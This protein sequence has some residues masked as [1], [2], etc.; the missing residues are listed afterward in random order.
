MKRSLNTL[1]TC[2]FVLLALPLAADTVLIR[3]VEVVSPHAPPTGE[4]VNV[5]IDDGVIRAIGP[6]VPPADK[7]IDGR[8]R[9]L[10]PGL[11]DAH[12]HLQGVPGDSP[13]M[14]AAV[15][16]QALAQIPRSYLYF[17]FTSVLD[18]FSGDA[19]ITQWNSQLLA[20]TAYHCAGVP[21][22]GGYP[23]AALLSE[24]EK[25]Q[26]PATRFYQYD[27]RRPELMSATPGSERHKPEALVSRIAATGA[28]CIK[29]FYE[30]G[31][32]RMK[33]LPVPT[34]AMTRQLVAAA[35]K[36]GLP[37]FLHGNSLEAYQ[38]ALDTGV[39]MLVHGLWSGVRPPTRKPL[40]TW[41]KPSPGTACAFS[42]RS[43]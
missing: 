23:L 15:R 25:L 30:T 14:P 27:P 41:P 2:I 42:P 43:G 40:Y 1:I 7:V 31:F 29:T 17:G 6:D 33:K 5:L 38:F 4:G 9:Y 28:R 3:E 22:L 35:H 34:P 19:L 24:P 11:I 20:P 32:G 36:Q 13:E 26:G 37:V 16:E 12:V 8:G 18:L 39:D 10:I 21:I